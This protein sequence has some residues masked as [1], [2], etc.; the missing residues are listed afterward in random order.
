MTLFA[1]PN[2]KQCFIACSQEK[3]QA[4]MCLCISGINAPVFP[5]IPSPTKEHKCK[6]EYNKYFNDYVCSCG[7]IKGL[8]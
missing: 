2:D 4:G 6:F 3:V 8:Q 5:N 1:Q 7:E